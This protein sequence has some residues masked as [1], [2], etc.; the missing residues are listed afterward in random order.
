MP[1]ESRY[2]IKAEHLRILRERDELPT[3]AELG[4]KYPDFTGGLTSEE[5]VR[6]M[7]DG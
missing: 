5:Y 6:R 2:R 1:A 7:R 3:I 4:G